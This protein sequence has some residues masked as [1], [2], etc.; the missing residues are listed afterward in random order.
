MFGFETPT[1]RFHPRFSFRCHG[2]RPA[3]EVILQARNGR[4]ADQ[5]INVGGIVGNYPDSR[6]VFV[7]LMQDARGADGFAFDADDGVR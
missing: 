6:R 5:V 4:I 1:A 2:P 3:A 7:A